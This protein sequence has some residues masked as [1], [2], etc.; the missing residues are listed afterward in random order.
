[1]GVRRPL[2]KA[3]CHPPPYAVLI[4][5]P[6][7]D[8]QVYWPKVNSLPMSP[9]TPPPPTLPFV[10]TEVHYLYALGIDSSTHTC[11]HTYICIHTSCNTMSSTHLVIQCHVSLRTEPPLPVYSSP[12]SRIPNQY[13]QRIPGGLNPR[14]CPEHPW[15]P[16]SIPTVGRPTN[17]KSV[18]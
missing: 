4:G 13:F 8:E 18:G 15:Q 10:Q 16:W 17:S 12:I 11:M 5:L 6:L 9:A 3:V 7:I 1:M 2:P 14:V